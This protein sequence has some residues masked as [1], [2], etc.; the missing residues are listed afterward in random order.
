[1]RSWIKAGMFAASVGAASLMVTQPASA[2]SCKGEFANPITDLCWSCMFP[3]SV[4]G[5]DIINDGQLDYDTGV[6]GPLCNCGLEV[7]ITVSF[8]EPIRRI[9]VSRKPFCL[10]SLGGVEIDPGV[11]AP[12]HGRSLNG[13]GSESG[14]TDAFYQAH[15]YQDP[16]L[17]WMEVVMDNPCMEK[18]PFDLAYLTEVDPMWNDD[19]LTLIINPE[20]NMFT[21]MASHAA[22]AADCVAA[23]DGVPQ[24]ELF[25]CA[26]CQGSLYP[27]TGNLSNHTSGPISSSVILQRLLTKMHRQFTLQSAN[28]S[29]GLCGYYPQPLIDKREYK[30]TM[31][32]P[33]PQTEKVGGQCC[34]P[35]GR[36]TQ[37]WA[38][39]KE[40]PYDG[41]DFAYQVFRKRDCC[42]GAFSVDDLF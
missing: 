41:E 42:Q 20:A 13:T 19:E 33:I 6:D 12:E 11:D 28:G 24:K 32:Y 17:Y 15:Y 16:I 39:G 18:S 4:G 14:Q 8:W 5:I 23:T 34:Q 35:L 10:V 1:M 36:T 27:L 22:C 2:T 37:I 30:Y 21:S 26:G 3:I 38:S 9:G 25:W 40:F 29:E 7:G 31:L